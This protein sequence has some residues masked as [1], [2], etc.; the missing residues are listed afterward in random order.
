MYKS[1]VDCTYVCVRGSLRR[2]WRT[3]VGTEKVAEAILV[4]ESVAFGIN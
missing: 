4:V 2:H 3:D 1:S